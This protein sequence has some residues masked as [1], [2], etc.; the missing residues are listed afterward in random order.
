MSVRQISNFDMI[1]GTHFVRRSV[2]ILSR[3]ATKILVKSYTSPTQYVSFAPY[4]S[5]GDN[6]LYAQH[7]RHSFRRTRVKE[8]LR[9]TAD[10]SVRLLRLGSVG[11]RSTTPSSKRL[12]RWPKR[13][14]GARSE[15]CLAAC[16]F[17][18]Q[19]KSRLPANPYTCHSLASQAVKAVLIDAVMY[20][21]LPATQG[22][23]H[24]VVAVSVARWSVFL[25][26]PQCWHGLGK[27]CCLHSSGRIYPI[28]LPKPDRNIKETL[29][30]HHLDCACGFRA[31][32]EMTDI[33]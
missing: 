12:I 32:W 27:S 31:S 4:T 29:P 19:Q 30:Q 17:L 24:A 28:M 25:L 22:H 3:M 1:H 21:R 18:R 6:N 15:R 8:C 13:D 2:H 26:A 33:S 14:Y 23:A 10:V 20:T 5:H 9:G 7:I 11:G 16:A